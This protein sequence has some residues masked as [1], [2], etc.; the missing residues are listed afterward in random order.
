MGITYSD[1][2]YRPEPI[3]NPL[4]NEGII[5]NQYYASDTWNAY[6]K[7]KKIYGANGRSFKV[8]NYGYAKDTW[9]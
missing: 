3:L 8:L 1:Y 7:G 9:N 2:A 6:Y 4:K 5:Y